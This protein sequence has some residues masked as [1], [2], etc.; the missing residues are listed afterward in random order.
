MNRQ[1]LSRPPANNFAANTAFNGAMAN[2]AE[3]KKKLRVFRF[4]A[5]T[6]EMGIFNSVKA[7]RARSTRPQ[8]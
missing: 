1:P 5:G 2:P 3:F 8:H 6:V 4:G 7:L